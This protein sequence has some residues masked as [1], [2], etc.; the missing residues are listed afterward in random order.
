MDTAN[1][2]LDLLTHVSMTH[3][4]VNRSTEKSAP[5]KGQGK[6]ALNKAIII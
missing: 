3:V 4:F 6:E 1:L 5:I 2:T